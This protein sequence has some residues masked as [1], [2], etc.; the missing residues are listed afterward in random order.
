MKFN[1]SVTT[2]VLVAQILLAVTPFIPAT[3]TYWRTDDPREFY[4][5]LAG[6]VGIQ[7][8]LL[9]AAITLILMKESSDAEGRLK[10]L[11]EAMPGAIVKRLKDFQFYVH[12]RNAAEQAEHSVWI[13]YFAAYP[14][15]DVASKER[16]KYDE[17]MLALMKHRTRVN[18]R[19]II[20]HSSANREWVAE[21]IAALRDRANVDI[22]VLTRDLP[23]NEEMPLALSVQVVDKDKVWIVAAGS[24]QT[25]QTFRDVYIE[26]SDVAEAMIEY[27]DR[28]W[29]KSV[30]VLDHGRI[31][32]EGEKMIEG[33]A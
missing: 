8:I 9:T 22:G 14:P 19:R 33:I 16:K 10:A 30:V 4:G 31:T 26:N 21:L 23:E 12:F 2:L 17:D 7:L 29:Q 13:A 28:I 15:K 3:A 32:T 18:F 6:F 27:Y 24:H 25:K 1:L 11:K 5:V 20:R